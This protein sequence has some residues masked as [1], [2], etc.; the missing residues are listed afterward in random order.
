MVTVSCRVCKKK[1]YGKPSHIE[2]G[3]AKYCSKKCSNVGQH[4]GETFSCNTCGKE[5]YRTRKEMRCSA[6]N[7]FYCGKAC[8][9]VWKNQNLFY[10]ENHANWK[11]GESAYRNVLLRAKIQQACKGCGYTNKKVLLVH[12]IDRNRKNNKVKN[13]M[14]LCRNCHYLIHNGKTI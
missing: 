6:S 10:G 5:V 8:F 9:A 3:W 14:W 11:N 4:N 13:L 12:H 1:F 2:R 7:K